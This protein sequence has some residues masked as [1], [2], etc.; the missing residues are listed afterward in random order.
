MKKAQFIS[1]SKKRFKF[2]LILGIILIAISTIGFNLDRD[3]LIVDI[4]SVKSP[5]D[6]FFVLIIIGLFVSIISLINLFNKSKG[7][8]LG[9]YYHFSGY[10][11][12]PP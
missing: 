3:T 7:L 1:V 11:F 9:F 12:K 6:M 5:Y 2:I 10:R 4:F 8:I